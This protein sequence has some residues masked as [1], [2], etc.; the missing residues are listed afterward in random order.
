MSGKIIGFEPKPMQTIFQNSKILI[1]NL[2]S[3]SLS[4]SS[5]ISFKLGENSLSNYNIFPEILE[6]FN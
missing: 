6:N 2:N 4:V 3:I 5:N 1:S